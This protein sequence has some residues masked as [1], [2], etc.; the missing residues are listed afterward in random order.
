[1][2]SNIARVRR[3]TL[4]SFVLLL[5]T[6]MQ[7]T[8]ARAT[9]PGAELSFRDGLGLNYS[10]VLSWDELQEK[11]EPERLRFR[12]KI[13]GEE[14][15]HAAE[16]QAR[17]GV[18]EV[19]RQLE[20][21]IADRVGDA[22]VVVTACRRSVVLARPSDPDNRG[23]MMVMIDRAGG[24]EVRVVY[25]GDWERVLAGFHADGDTLRGE[26]AAVF[27]TGVLEVVGAFGAGATLPD[28][29]DTPGKL[30]DFIA[31]TADIFGGVQRIAYAEWHFGEGIN[32]VNARSR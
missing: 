15:S 16:I 7:P 10:L 18:S 24:A 2:D 28:S 30:T 6:L 21:V 8:E 13:R 27:L 12:G 1:M 17:L 32:A 25:W 31:A 3:V 29:G 26:P 14:G 22:T 11:G 23:D 20:D 4:A 19:L 5:V 9:P